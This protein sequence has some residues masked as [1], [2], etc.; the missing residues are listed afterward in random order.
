MSGR[1]RLADFQA[2]SGNQN[3]GYGQQQQYGGNQ[4]GNQ[5]YGNQQYGNQQQQ[6]YGNQY[7][8]QQ[9]YGQ[10]Q[11]YGNQQNQFAQQN[12]FQQQQYG[13]Q[14][15]A[16][17]SRIEMTSVNHNN[18]GAAGGNDMNAFFSEV[19]SIQ[20][21]IT[22]IEQNI[23]KIEEMHDVSL[24]SVTTEDQTAKT[25]RQ[26][27]G[28]TADTTQLSNRTKK[29]IKDI[30]LANLRL[31]SS[32]E[33][34]IRR[35]Q[36]ASLKE[37]FLKTLRRYQS[38]ES[39]ARKKY[40]GRMERQY[41]IVK[42]DA[43]PQEI[44]Q[45]MESDN[46]QIFAQSVLNSTRYGDANRALREVQSRHDDIKKIEKTILELHQLF[47][48]M[49][50]LVTEQAEV[51][52]TIEENTQQTDIHLEIG[53]KEVDTAIVNARGAR[54]KKW[55]CL[56]I[57]LILLAIIVVVVLTQSGLLSGSGNKSK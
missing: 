44:A 42:P 37:K 1:D 43:T 51:M 20:E 50:T 9:G 27:E 15:P 55:I 16:S 52:N 45:V 57:T 22:K 21:D 3:Q 25:T 47:I 7:G 12:Q 19:T 31:A 10:Q 40:Q 5:Q 34:Q 49:E 56:I 46:Q 18:N 17:P 48:D 14:Q 38:A 32:P 8:Q 4:Y 29:R 28:L 23:S 30:E 53:N 13:Q 54:K 41:K 39:D 6:Q 11:Q 26:L 36:A 35:T 33:I 2:Q 24:N